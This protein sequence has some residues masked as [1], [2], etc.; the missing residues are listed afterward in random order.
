[1]KGRI[2]LHGQDRPRLVG[3][4]GGQTAGA[5]ADLEDHIAPGQLRILGDE[6]DQIEID[7]EVL[8]QLVLGPNA[9]LLEELAQE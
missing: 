4:R 5:G 3:Q 9:P 2:D 1:M 7:E 6:I 8:S